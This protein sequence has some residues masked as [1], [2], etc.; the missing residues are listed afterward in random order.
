MVDNVVA[1]TVAMVVVVVAVVVVV[2]WCVFVG[3]V[4]MVL[5]VEYC[6]D[7]VRISVFYLCLYYCWPENKGACFYSY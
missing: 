3:C 7:C 4:V 1:A 6:V 5:S 2:V